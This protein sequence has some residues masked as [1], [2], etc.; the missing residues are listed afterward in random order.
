MKKYL[1]LL[2]LL[3]TISGCKTMPLKPALVGISPDGDINAFKSQAQGDIAA[4]KGDISLLKGNVDKLV[5]A[6][7]KLTVALSAALTA[8]INASANIG[9]GNTSTSQTAQRD[10]ISKSKVTNEA[11]LMKNY[12][13]S[14]GAIFLIVIAAFIFLINKILNLSK[15]KNFYKSK[16]LLNIKSKKELEKLRKSHDEY[17]K[18]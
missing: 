3:L 14:V 11:G 8:N 17:L 16:T 7:I 1:L 18:K 13:W 2:L 10:I 15:R 6:N 12:I 4:L 9:V 5:E